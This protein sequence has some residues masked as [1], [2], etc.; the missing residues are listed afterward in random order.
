MRHRQTRCSHVDRY[1]ANAE[2]EHEYL[3]ANR[4]RD[5]YYGGDNIHPC[6]IEFVD[7]VNGEAISLY[8]RVTILPCTAI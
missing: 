1:R 4:A 6:I 7:D 2:H 3:C 5:T 8:P